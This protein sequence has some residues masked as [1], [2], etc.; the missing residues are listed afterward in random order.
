[1][2]IQFL[3]EDNVNYMDDEITGHQILEL[4]RQKD[5][6]NLLIKSGST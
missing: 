4:L 2:A 1:M 5:R 3:Y 6:V